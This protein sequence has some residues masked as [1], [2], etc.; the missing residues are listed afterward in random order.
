M[1]RNDHL[2]IAVLTYRRPE[3]L[4]GLL[5]ELAV[6]AESAIP[7]SVEIVVVDNDPEASAR[8]VV[9]AFAGVR[10]VHEPAPGI[11]H[12]R[13]R[14]LVEAGDAKL[15]VFIDDDERPSAGWLASLL[16]MYDRTGA[17]GVTGPVYPDYEGVP[18]PWLVSAGIFI[19]K[20]H[21]DGTEMPAA[22]TGNL[23]L[24]LKQVHELGLRFDERFGLTGGSDTL[25]T[26]Q[27]VKAG[28]RIVYAAGASIVDK[29]PA[30]RMS[31]QWGR[32]RYF[33]VGNTWSRTSIELT[34]GPV[35]R[36]LTR[37]RLAV[38]GLARTG[39]GVARA[40]VGLLTGNLGHR[41]RGE[42]AIA[43][44]LGMVTGAWGR[45][46]IEYRRP[47]SAAGVSPLRAAYRRV[48]KIAKRTSS[49]VAMMLL[50]AQNRFSRT[51][52]VGDGAAMVSLTSYG[53]RLDV[54]AYTIESIA[55][56]QVR[57]R[58]FVLWIQEPDLYEA[59]S[60]SLR[61]LERRGLE[62]RLTDMLGPHTKYFPSLP[63]ALADQ[64]PLIT[65][66]DD[67]IY[68]RSWLAGLL[69][70]GRDHPDA[71]NCYRASVVALRQGVIAPYASWPRCNDAAP[72]PTHFAT[73][74]S[75]IRYPLTML[76]ALADKGTEFVDRCPRA[77]DIWLHWVALRSGIPVRQIS[78]RARH[79][80]YLPG[81]QE[82]TLVK[83]NV[84]Q[85]AN[86]RYI[87][88]LYEPRDVAVLAEAGAPTV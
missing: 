78:A 72:S 10:Y 7:R 70:A 82:T 12:G 64:L 80:P 87:A 62:V 84:G 37:I 36:V 35:E 60:A 20:E 16:S 49:H 75:G 24:D 17:A 39:Y 21:P 19:R 76:A 4:A 47:G 30:A 8:D 25:F 77:D 11:A 40:G 5:P 65:A 18:D 88:G 85:G 13:N 67:T 69:V 86:D 33:R 59:R 34:G 52:V 42:R 74:V 2:V 61:R 53:T 22:G 50:K 29:V 15:L 73:G 57:P 32:Q 83:E 23:L 54:V 6:Q 44:G 71:V 31:R 45:V 28:R 63:L 14:A 56:G 81:T 58:R 1:N 3:E 55:A 9:E 26:R 41:A 48:R 38:L 79:F 46:Y 66:D 51:P 27:L 43:R 68:P